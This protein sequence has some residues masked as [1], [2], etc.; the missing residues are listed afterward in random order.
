[1]KIA[2]LYASQYKNQTEHLAKSIAEDLNA[3]LYR[4]E[5]AH[6]LDT[7]SYD[8]LI[9]GSG[10]YAWHMH[11]SLTEWVDK[12]P[13]CTS[14][15]E[16]ILFST[17]ATKNKAFHDR[18]RKILEEKGY[19]ILAEYQ[20][21]IPLRIRKNEVAFSFEDIKKRQGYYTF[22]NRLKKLLDASTDENDEFYGESLCE[23]E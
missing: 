22:I 15:R 6:N 13:K 12:L 16:V 9:A 17:S 21:K 20:M 19:S 8:L 7:S 10:I 2:V 11:P 1:M 23:V 14:I 4:L 3:D 5:D 18:P